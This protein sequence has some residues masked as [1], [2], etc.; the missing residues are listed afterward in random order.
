VSQ[1]VE[2]FIAIAV[3]NSDPTIRKLA[4]L[5]SALQYKVLYVDVLDMVV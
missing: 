3:R 1:K 5:M 2:F 4:A